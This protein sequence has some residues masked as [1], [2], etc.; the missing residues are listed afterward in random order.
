MKWVTCTVGCAVAISLAGCAPTSPVVAD[1][2]VAPS[3]AAAFSATG[4]P[5]ALGK[6]QDV[7]PPHRH[8][9]QLLDPTERPARALVCEYGSVFNQGPGP[10]HTLA[11]QIDLDAAPAGRLGSAVAR[12]D[13]G[14]ARGPVSCP[15]DTGKVTVLVFTYNDSPPVNLWWHTTGCQSI[16]N[17]DVEANQI[18]N[19]SF[20][21][22]L[23]VFEAVTRPAA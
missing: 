23:T 2:F 14:A 21:A 4:C 3:P 22:F 20:G 9:S 1:Q 8:L 11:K 5:P 13:V 17:G 15:N 12:I 6:L 18:A 19:D 10:D 7:A 16:N